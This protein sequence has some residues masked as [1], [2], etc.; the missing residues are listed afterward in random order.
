MAA[1]SSTA[2][3]ALKHLFSKPQLASTLAVLAILLAALAIV[4]PWFRIDYTTSGRSSPLD[5]Y[6]LAEWVQHNPNGARIVTPYDSRACVCDRVE[7]VFTQTQL[8]IWTGALLAAAAYWGRSWTRLKSDQ[9]VALT[10]IA[11]L[12]MIAA[13]MLLALGLPRAFLDDGWAVQNVVPQGRWGSSFLGAHAEDLSHTVYW[14]PG[15]AWLL[16]LL[17]GGLTLASVFIERRRPVAVSADAPEAKRAP[18]GAVA[19]PPAAPQPL[20]P[21]AGP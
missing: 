18:S 8:L 17:A 10:A 9:A 16:A 7:G 3:R 19:A 6:A 20:A 13:P 4:T 14:G 5:E 12:L 1:G 11:G 2:A 15:I 21:R